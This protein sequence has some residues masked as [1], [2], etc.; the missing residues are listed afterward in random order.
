MPWGWEEGERAGGGNTGSSDCK[1]DRRKKKQ[2]H[3]LVLTDE[4]AATTP[5]HFCVSASRK[6][7][8]A[9]SCRTWAATETLIC[10]VWWDTGEATDDGCLQMA[11]SAFCSSARPSASLL[12]GGAFP[13]D[14]TTSALLT[15][16]KEG[17]CATIDPALESTAHVN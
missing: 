12:G 7:S 14:R 15:Q 2:K 5:H 13:A 1:V 10:F 11:S 8:F 9:L 4:E 17:R 6:C 3:K 16:R